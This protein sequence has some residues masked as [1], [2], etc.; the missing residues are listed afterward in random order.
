MFLQ[1]I[2]VIKA[3][4]KADPEALKTKNSSG[5]LSIHCLFLNRGPSMD[6]LSFIINSYPDACSISDA[7]GKLP[8]HY[9]CKLEGITDEVFEL[10]FCIHP[11]GAQA[12]DSFGYLPIDY[13]SSNPDKVAKEAALTALD[14][15]KVSAR[16]Y[17]VVTPDESS[18]KGWS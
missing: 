12:I 13:A 16:V 8:I 18:W 11:E 6:V 14:E 1:P 7:N 4:V 17:E 3:F 10:I 5:R 2:G 9:A 15:S